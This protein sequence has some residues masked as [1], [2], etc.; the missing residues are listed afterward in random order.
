VTI[1]EII[2]DARDGAR[3]GSGGSWRIVRRGNVAELWH[4]ATEMLS[5]NVERP[6]DP[7][8][9]DYSIGWGSVSDQS[10]LNIAFKVLDLP[11]HYSRDAKGGGPRIEPAER[12]SEIRARCEREAR[13]RRATYER[14]RAAAVERELQDCQLI[15]PAAGAE[16]RAIVYGQAI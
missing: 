3:A 6:D 4:Y 2:R 11:L 16:L 15:G 8:V 7:A 1:S 13:E 9:L 10:A 14:E 12:F 5:W